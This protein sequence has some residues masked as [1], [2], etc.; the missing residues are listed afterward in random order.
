MHYIKID[1]INYY[2][3]VK[4][5]PVCR[6]KKYVLL[7]P[8]GV[9]TKIRSAIEDTDEGLADAPSTILQR[10]ELNRQVAENYFFV[11]GMGHVPEIAVPDF[12][13]DLVGQCRA[14][15]FIQFRH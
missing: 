5:T 7:D 11:P 15:I 1:I 3:D 4:P 12:L 8:L 14:R 13:P 9:V 6:Y 2:Y 10:E